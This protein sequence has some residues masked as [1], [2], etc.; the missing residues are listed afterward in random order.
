MKKKDPYEEAFADWDW[1]DI[2]VSGILARIKS[3]EI[4]LPP[5]TDDEYEWV[6]LDEIQGDELFEIVLEATGVTRAEILIARMK[7]LAYR[8]RHGP[9]DGLVHPKDP[10]PVHPEWTVASDT[11]IGL[12]GDPARAME[13]FYRVGLLVTEPPTDSL[14]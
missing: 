14:H 13:L 5:P 6:D 7:G 1:D 4:P 12:Y 9:V 3:G 11:G 10:G 8:N 2:D